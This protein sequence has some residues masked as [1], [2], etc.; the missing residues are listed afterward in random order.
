MSE[1]LMSFTTALPDANYRPVRWAST[2][3]RVVVPNIVSPVADVNEARRKRFTELSDQWSAETSLMSS[4]SAMI[5]HPA[6][7]S[8][9]GMGVPVIGLIL[10]RLER[11]PDFWFEALR[12]LTGQN[13]V[14]QEDVG[15]LALM[16]HAWLSWG[17]QNGYR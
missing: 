15:D 10:E 4:I 6:Y 17:E 5:A 2:P 13:P 16:T 9:I 1:L 8:I 14:R 7:R 11:D 12:Q 3:T